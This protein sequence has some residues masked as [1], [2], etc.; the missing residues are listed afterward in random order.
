MRSRGSCGSTSEHDR[1]RHRPHRAGHPRPQGSA[2]PAHARVGYSTARNSPAATSANICRPAASLTAAAATATPSPRRSSCRCSASS[3]NAAPGAPNGRPSTTHESRSPS[4]G[5]ERISEASRPGKPQ[6]RDAW[7]AQV[8]G[9]VSHDTI[10]FKRLAG[11]EC[12][13]KANTFD[14]RRTKP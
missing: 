13:R 10:I 6:V 7:S 8:S 4:I 2:R 9:D 11:Q 5:A 12:C 3:R 1:R 14:G